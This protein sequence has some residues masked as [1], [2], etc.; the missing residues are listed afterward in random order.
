MILTMAT[1]VVRRE[2]AE[3]KEEKKSKK[4]LRKNIGIA[5]PHPEP[6]KM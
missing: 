3:G 6:Q 4:M 1:S 2:R 5:L